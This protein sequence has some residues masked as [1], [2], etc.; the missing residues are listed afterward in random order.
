MST[1]TGRHWCGDP[2]IGQYHATCID[3]G[4]CN[5]IWLW[6]DHR[7]DNIVVFF[8]SNRMFESNVRIKCS[9]KLA[10]RTVRERTRRANDRRQT[11]RH[12]R[13][14]FL[15]SHCA[16]I[17]PYILY[18]ICDE[19]DNNVVVG[20]AGIILLWRVAGNSQPLSTTLCRLVALFCRSIPASLFMTTL[21]FI[22]HCHWRTTS[23]SDTFTCCCCAHYLWVT[24]QVIIKS[25]Y[26]RL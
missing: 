17:I 3:S 15:W 12:P 25:P 18:N 23:G 21:S 22:H 24:Q 16:H 5:S 26:E 11:I 2:D 4:S 14:S 9:N 6:L 7:S 13:A 20:V 19:P 8:P 10:V 1:V